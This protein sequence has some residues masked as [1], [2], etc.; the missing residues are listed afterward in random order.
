MKLRIKVDGSREVEALVQRIDARLA[1]L[2][3]PLN[4]VVTGTP[5][6]AI[7]T[8]QEIASGPFLSI[9]IATAAI[10]LLP[11][12]LFTSAPAGLIALLPTVVPVGNYF[13]THG[14]SEEGGVGQGGYRTGGSWGVAS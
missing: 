7:R 6:L 3:P 5:I 2:P 8:V 11:T 4:G 12:F 9:A 1:A 13:G 14:R 10:W